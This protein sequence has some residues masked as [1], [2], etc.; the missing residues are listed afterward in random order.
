VTLLPVD[1]WIVAG[2]ALVAGIVLWLRAAQARFVAKL[3]AAGDPLAEETGTKRFR[4]RF[5]AHLFGLDAGGDGS[6]DRRGKERVR[7]AAQGALTVVMLLLL[8]AIAVY[9][10]V[11]EL[12]E[13]GGE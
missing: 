8:G 13:G 5:Q 12:I 3:R 7:K 4:Q 2:L 10:L 1:V 6:G 11:P 9:S